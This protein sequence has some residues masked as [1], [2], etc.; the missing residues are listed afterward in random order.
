MMSCLRQVEPIVR[1]YAVT[2]PSG[3]IVP[4][5]PPGW[6]QVVYAAAGAVTVVTPAGRWVV[7]PT[8]AVW[9]PDGV[10]HRIEVTGRARLRNLYLAVGVARGWSSPRALDMR[11]LARELLLEVVRRAPIDSTDE[12][13]RRLVDVLVDELADLPD[14]PLHLP[15]PTDDRARRVAEAILAAPGDRRSLDE[16]AAMAGASRRTVERRFADETGIPL[17]RWRTHA[18]IGHALRL[19]ADGEPTAQV[20]TRVG[21]STPSA[22]VA[23]FRRTLGT[24]PQRWSRRRFT[25]WR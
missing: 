22:F 19:L 8:R 25:R 2:H 10:V 4:P 17:A 20:A 3:T 23:A 18:R 9:V 14:A 21:F 13:S 12:P 24:T 7:P 1:S 6:D 11:P 5:Q 15:L 16:L